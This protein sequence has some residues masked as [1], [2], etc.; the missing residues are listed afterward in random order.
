M[1]GHIRAVIAAVALLTILSSVN[2]AC[3]AAFVAS[4]MHL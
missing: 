2:P 3:A 4:S 1:R